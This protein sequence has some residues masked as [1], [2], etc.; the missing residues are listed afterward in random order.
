[1]APA[2]EQIAARELAILL[3]DSRSDRRF[4]CDRNTLSDC[5][6]VDVALQSYRI[7]TL[8]V[9]VHPETTLS[10]LPVIEVLVIWMELR[11]SCESFAIN[12]IIKV[13]TVSAS[14]PEIEEALLVST[15]GGD[16]LTVGVFRALGNNID[17][18]INGVRS[19][20][21]CARTSDDFYPV[22]ILHQRVLNFPINAGI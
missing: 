11:T 1:M 14:M 9:P 4:R 3:D 22:Y 21:R 16:E 18:A 19:P 8:Q 12:A 6:L 10:H 5:A 7:P 15:A 20:D 2:A 17:H 13:R